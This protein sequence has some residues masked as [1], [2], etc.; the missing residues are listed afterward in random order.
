MTEAAAREAGAPLARTRSAASWAT[1][2]VAG[3]LLV[4]TA[5]AVWADRVALDTGVFVDTSSELIENEAI[6]SAVATRAVDELFESVDVEAE[7]EGQLP[8]DLAALSGPATAALREASYELVERALRQRALQRLWTIALEQSHR[9]LVAV[10]EGDGEALSTEG[11]AVTLDLEAIVLEAAD[12]IGLRSQV[13]DKLPADVGRVVVLRSD[14]LDAAQD[15]FRVLSTLA[16]LLPLL[17]LAAFALALWLAADRRRGVARTGLVLLAAGV[18]G[19]VA[20]HLLGDYLVRSLAEEAET[21]RAADHAW[22]IVSEPLRAS[23]RWLLVV[24]A[25]FVAAAALAGA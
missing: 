25:L 12:R 8:D 9:T 24:G 20:A 6:R 3:A 18:A 10:L 7:V 2:V 14:E 5:F 21:R 22:G 4:L 15:G 23:L 13:E 16:W 17:T 11:G 19:L 1:L